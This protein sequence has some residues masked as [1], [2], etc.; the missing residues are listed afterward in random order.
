MTDNF[1]GTRPDY[2]PDF[3]NNPDGGDAYGVVKLSL[4][5]SRQLEAVSLNRFPPTFSAALD[6]KSA[7]YEDRLW[8]GDEEDWARM[9]AELLPRYARDGSRVALFWGNLALPTVTLSVDVVVRYAREIL[10]A[11]PHFWIYPLDGSVLIECLMDGQ[12]TIADIP[13]S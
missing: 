3:M 10:D 6:W 13:S 12:V 9:A 7:S 11:G 4:A 5:E 1:Y 8:W 2:L